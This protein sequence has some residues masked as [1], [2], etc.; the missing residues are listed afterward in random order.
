MAKPAVALM[1]AAR[2]VGGAAAVERWVGEVR[3]VV[4]PVA[5]VEEAAEMEG[6]VAAEVA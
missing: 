1:A 2:T 3:E 6:L 5:A 4:A